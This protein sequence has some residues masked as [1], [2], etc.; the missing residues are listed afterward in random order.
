MEGAVRSGIWLLAGVCIGAALA[1]AAFAVHARRPAPDGPAGP[2]SVAEARQLSA[3][4]LA[5]RGLTLAVDQIVDAIP[6][7]PKGLPGDI[8]KSLNSLSFAMTPYPG[9]NGVCQSTVIG[10]E[11]KTL[12]E[13][14]NQ[15]ENAPATVDDIGTRTLYKIRGNLDL[16]AE[17]D[18]EAMAARCAKDRPFRD[19][20][21]SATNDRV[22]SDVGLIFATIK[23]DTARGKPT[24]AVTCEQ[25]VDC[26]D[27]IRLLASLDIDRVTYAQSE[28]DCA[29]GKS[30]YEIMITNAAGT[31]TALRL[32]KAVT[33]YRGVGTKGWGILRLEKLF[34]QHEET[35]KPLPHA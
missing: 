20:Y 17:Q 22:A 6:A 16:N 2:L 30:C 7:P 25:A 11:M 9:W 4:A 29:D 19:S 21:F 33:D 23:A 13:P 34:I 24:F 26:A 32:M 35:V 28:D 10:L 27:P 12:D 31:P 15:D 1:A 8:D 3:K 5:A 18:D 14:A